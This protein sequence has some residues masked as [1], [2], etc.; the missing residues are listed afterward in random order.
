[1][2]APLSGYRVVDFATAL[3]GPWA[4]GILADQGADVIKVEPRTGDFTRTQ[5][6]GP[7]GVAALFASTN[8]NKRSIAV[9]LKQPRGVEL[10]RRLVAGADVFV[11]NFRPG[12]IDKLGLGETALREI[13]PNLLYVSLS[14]FGDLREPASE[15]VALRGFEPRSDG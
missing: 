2:T 13:R 4:A 5:G 14:G 10:V 1:M 8:R 9:D 11:Q 12:A 15:R 7:R 3:S 6:A